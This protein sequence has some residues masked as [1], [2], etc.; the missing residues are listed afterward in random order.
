MGETSLLLCLRVN[1]DLVR[2]YRKTGA[3]EDGLTRRRTEGR[4]RAEWTGKQVI[5]NI[6]YAA[7]NILTSK[8]K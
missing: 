4:T 2:S 7:E 6:Q 8:D 5:E 1:R 3:A